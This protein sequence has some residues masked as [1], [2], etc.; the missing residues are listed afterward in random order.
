MITRILAVLVAFVATISAA[1]VPKE[2][3]AEGNPF[4]NAKVGDYTEYKLTL[5]DAGNPNVGR[6]K[7]VVSA[8]TEKEVT[9]QTT[10]DFGRGSTT[11]PGIQNRPDQTLRLLRHGRGASCERRKTVGRKRETRGRR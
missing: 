1:P 11:G 5:S 4:K 6:I 9:I 3:T 7:I 10:T 2:L 8:V